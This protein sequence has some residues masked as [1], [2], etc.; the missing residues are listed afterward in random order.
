MLFPE[1]K[2]VS[3][4]VLGVRLDVVNPVIDADWFP[5]LK[6][7]EVVTLDDIIEGYNNG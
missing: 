6:D 4:G 1:C 7:G 2:V 3:Q 5:S